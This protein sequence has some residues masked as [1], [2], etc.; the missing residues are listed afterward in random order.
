MDD[1]EFFFVNW[2]RIASGEEKKIETKVPI[3][4]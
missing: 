1:H 4:L 3:R 2:T